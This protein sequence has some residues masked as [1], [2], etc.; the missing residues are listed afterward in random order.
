MAVGQRAGHQPIEEMEVFRL[1]EEVSRWVWTEVSR[2]PAFAQQTVGLQLVRAVDSVNANLVEG[3]G[4]FSDADALRHFLIAR[5]SAR[6]ARL[7]LNRA[8]ER[9]LVDDEACQ[10]QV[11][12]INS[13]TRLLNQ[14]INYRRQT[15]SR[16]GVREERVAY[17]KGELADPTLESEHDII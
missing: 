12:R 5:G 6:E 3:D 9:K 13:A 14:L 2:W 10:Q 17:N 1:Y 7:W 8:V 11:G 4:R 16:N 15:L